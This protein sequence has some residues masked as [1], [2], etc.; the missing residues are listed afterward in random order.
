LGSYAGDPKDDT[1]PLETAL[2]MTMDTILQSTDGF[3]P[4]SPTA[5]RNYQL[6]PRGRKYDGFRIIVE[7]SRTAF[8]A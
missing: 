7:D 6:S 4:D 8:Y 3:V 2:A 1:D 5:V